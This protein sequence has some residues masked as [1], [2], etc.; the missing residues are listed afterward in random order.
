[1]I[2]SGAG[3]HFNQPSYISSGSFSFNNGRSINCGWDECEQLFFSEEDFTSHL[4]E[5]HVDPQMTFDCPLQLDAC[6]QNITS[7][8]LTHLKAVHGFDPNG[9]G[10]QCPAADC[11]PQIFCNPAD[12]HKHLDLAHATPATG[13]LQCGWNSCG[14]VF[15]DQLQLLNHLPHHFLV[16]DIPNKDKNVCIVDFPPATPQYPPTISENI[17]SNDKHTCKWKVGD[18]LCG[19]HMRDEGDLQEHIKDQHL[20]SMDSKT[21]YFCQWENCDRN[22]G[23]AA[24]GKIAAFTQRQKLERHMASHTL[25]KPLHWLREYTSNTLL[26]KSSMCHI[27]Q[28]KFSAKQALKQHMYTHTGEKPWKCKYPGCDKAFAQQSAHSMSTIYIFLYKLLMGPLEMHERTHTGEKP[29][30]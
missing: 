24:T 13:S 1:L 28:K 8:P 21:G 20:S 7:N 18:Q 25:C 23:A 2:R 15:Q 26:D 5:D 10:Y 19:Q 4:H 3:T 16:P 14:D 22:L 29:L 6:P 30:V 12:L 11:P 17:V 9:N 27:C